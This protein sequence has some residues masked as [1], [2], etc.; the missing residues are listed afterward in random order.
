VGDPYA[1]DNHN[2]VIVLGFCGERHA[3]PSAG[4]VLKRRRWR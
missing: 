3:I 2:L 1:V 4:F